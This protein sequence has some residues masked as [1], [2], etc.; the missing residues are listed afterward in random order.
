M[1]DHVDPRLFWA[2]LT[3][4]W[5][6][7]SFGVSLLIGKIIRWADSHTPRNRYVNDDHVAATKRTHA[8]NG[9]KSR[10]GIR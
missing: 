7:V 9:F 6:I 10:Q 5:L 2:G 8:R 3:V 1:F 4:F